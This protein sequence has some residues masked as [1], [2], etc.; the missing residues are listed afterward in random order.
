MTE[1]A[2]IEPAT[3][4]SH[5][6]Q[7]QS[8]AFSY[9]VGIYEDHVLVAKLSRHNLERAQLTLQHKEGPYGERLMSWG[10]GSR[11]EMLETFAEELDSDDFAEADRVYAASPRNQTLRSRVVR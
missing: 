1:P 4:K 10:C 11:E 6:D 3:A 9:L 7:L 2:E 8:R 5:A